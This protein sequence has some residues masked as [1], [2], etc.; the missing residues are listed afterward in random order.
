[1]AVQSEMNAVVS[2]LRSAIGNDKKQ[3]TTLN[4]IRDAFKAVEAN[5]LPRSEM[6]ERSVHLVDV[7]SEI[8]ASL[9]KTRPRPT[10]AFCAVAM[11][12]LFKAKLE[13]TLKGGDEEDVKVWEDTIF[14]GLLQPILSIIDSEDQDLDLVGNTMYGEICGIMR[15]P[16]SQGF[17]GRF[18]RS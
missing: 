15:S 17:G 1:M 9:Y 4:K 12:W 6:V 3:K 14:R 7:I 13:P 18:A 10:L 11:R 2:A 16:W 8:V 5:E